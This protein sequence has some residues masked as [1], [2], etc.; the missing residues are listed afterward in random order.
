MSSYSKPVLAVLTEHEE[1]GEEPQET[2]GTFILDHSTNDHEAVEAAERLADASTK[3]LKAL[4]VA[5][6]AG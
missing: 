3:L 5:I 1:A 4:K 2:L 6:R